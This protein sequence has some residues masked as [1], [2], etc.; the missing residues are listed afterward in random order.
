MEEG[1]KKQRRK[2]ISYDRVPDDGT[3]TGHMVALFS[4][5]TLGALT[6]IVLCCYP[7]LCGLSDN[8]IITLTGAVMLGVVFDC[9]IV[10]HLIG[11]I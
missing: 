6:P 2:V 10:L 11:T 5:I 7:R 4:G 3:W 8:Q 1:D 9:L